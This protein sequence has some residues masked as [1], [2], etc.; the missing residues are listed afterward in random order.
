MK[1]PR[2]APEAPEV[3]YWVVGETGDRLVTCGLVARNGIVVRCAPILA[4]YR[5]KNTVGRPVAPVLT[6]ITLRG[7]R[8]VRLTPR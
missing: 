8:Y 1:R 4:R 5:G 7:W 2:K 3:L 6:G